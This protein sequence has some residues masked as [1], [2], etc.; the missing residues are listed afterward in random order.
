MNWA[1]LAVLL[2]M[3]TDAVAQ[4][5]DTQRPA[6]EA[7]PGTSLT[8]EIGGKSAELAV[9]DVDVNVTMDI[10]FDGT[11][12][13]RDDALEDT[14]SAIVI[15]NIDQAYDAIDPY[16]EPAQRKRLVVK[17]PMGGGTV[18]LR[19]SSANIHVLQA[20][21]GGADIFKGNANVVIHVTEGSYWVEGGGQASKA[22]GDEYIEAVGEDGE[23]NA[24]RPTDRVKITV[25]WV[26]LKPAAFGG[27]ATILPPP[28]YQYRDE[29]E[30][31]Q[32]HV[33][34]GLHRS[35]VDSREGPIAARGTVEFIGDIH[36]AISDRAVFGPAITTNLHKRLRGTRATA[37][38][39]F[40]FRRLEKYVWQVQCR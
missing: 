37:D 30:R 2:L 11:I 40:I 14:R 20:A 29:V 19:R 38:F 18:T 31:Q 26:D 13:A 7:Q 34:L 36:P 12:D 6:V 22:I 3:S 27:N 1:A 39:G 35:T 25:L 23:R 16:D 17:D 32:G 33:L 10:N 5:S 21:K 15:A 28:F 8:A 4:S 24:K 9:K